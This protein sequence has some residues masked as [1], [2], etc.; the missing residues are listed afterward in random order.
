MKNIKIGS[1]EVALADYAV[2][3]N[4]I[5]GIRDSGKTVTAKGIAEQLLDNDVQIIVFDAVGKWRWMKVAAESSRGK[6]YKVVV[7]GGREPDLP[8]TPHSVPEIVRAALKQ[9]IPLIID[10]FDKRL[11]KSDWRQIVQKAIHTIHYENESGAV[12]VILEEAAE[13]V[14]QKIYD[15]ET[16]GE[17]EKLV[18]MGGN[19]HVG[20][21]IINQRSQEVNKAVL[22]NCS[23]ALVLGCQVGKNAIEAVEKWIERL[24]PETADKVTTS[25]PRLQSG[26]AWVWTRKSLDKPTLE[27][28]PMCRSFHPDRRTP[29]I[30]L[31][32]AKATNIG[33]FVEKMSASIPKVIQEAKANDPAE[34]RRQ[35]RELEHNLNVKTRE[36]TRA[37]E[38]PEI[39][40]GKT[41]KVEVPIIR[42]SEHSCMKHIVESFRAAGNRLDDLHRQFIDTH[43]R[44]SKAMEQARPY[45]EKLEARLAKFSE[46][47]GPNKNHFTTKLFI[48]NTPPHKKGAPEIARLERPLSAPSTA[49]PRSS[50][51][52]FPKW[53]GENTAHD[54]TNGETPTGGLKRMLIA[55]AQ[56]PGLNARQLSLRSQVKQ[57][58]GS[59][60]TYISKGRSMGWLTGDKNKFELTQDGLNS[61]GEYI[62]LPE[63]KDLAEHYMRALGDSGDGR[64]FKVLFAAYPN[65]MTTEELSEA[66]NVSTSGG[67]FG[68]YLSKLRTLEL[69]TGD[70][71]A[72]KASDEFFQ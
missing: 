30:V 60:G 3:A 52:S 24:D 2:G 72:L 54:N 35:V 10:L 23:T 48:G 57:S 26:E 63:G 66:A 51:A 65:T 46:I 43:T 13:F 28:F 34:L 5:L 33:E 40:P 36:L 4:A 11:T 12:H 58:G 44:F 62:P 16:Y 53:K 20:I 42:A 1:I 41:E 45:I 69:V 64:M 19:A 6:A 37:L 15:A 22:D 9:R 21:T 17:V 59:F 14:P 61:I 8:L 49:L 18:R 67:S 29:E 27:K 50:V 25:L 71:T 31:K 7:A 56:R 70:K 32:E 38:S 68:T 39:K 55:L 47:T